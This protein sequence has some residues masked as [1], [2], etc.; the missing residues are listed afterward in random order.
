GL[1]LV[2]LS[3][4]LFVGGIAAESSA[5][6][7]SDPIKWI[8]QGSDVVADVDRLEDETGFATTLG[9]IV[10]A[11]NIYDQDVIDLVHEFTI[12][13]EQ[14]PEVV[15]SSSL[16]NTMAKIITIPGATAIPPTEEELLAASEVMPPDIARALVNG[17]QTAAQVN[18]RL[19]PANLEDR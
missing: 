18:L 9:V 4:G 3:I 13:A 11:N 19:A 15:S 2:L 10:K 8:D 17:D 6:I 14:R 1:V 12:D 16:V 7:E 5:R